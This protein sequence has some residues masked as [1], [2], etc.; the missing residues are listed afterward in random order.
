MNAE[1]WRRRYDLNQ[2]LTIHSGVS[3]LPLLSPVVHCYAVTEDR[4]E[5][6][7]D[8]TARPPASTALSK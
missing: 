3:H 1:L 2:R 7:P 4:V 8:I 5:I 6:P